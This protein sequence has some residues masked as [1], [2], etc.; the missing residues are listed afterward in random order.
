MKAILIP[1]I[2]VHFSNG[3]AMLNVHIYFLKITYFQVLESP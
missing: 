2:K 3:Q 1:I